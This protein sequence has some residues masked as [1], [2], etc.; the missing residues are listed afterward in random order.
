[1]RQQAQRMQT[2]V[3]DLLT[4]ARIEG[5]AP[6]APDRWVHLEA[7]VDA[8]RV[9]ATALSAGRHRLHW[10]PVREAVLLGRTELA[11]NETELRSALGNLLS[12]AVRYTPEGGEVALLLDLRSDGRLA[13]TVRDSGIGIAAE[14]L[15]RI[16]ERFYRVDGSRSR[17]TGGTGLG[18]AIVKHVAQRHGGELL[19]ESRP[20]EGS[21]FT[22]VMPAMRVR[23]S[24]GAVVAD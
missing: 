24:A 16:T 20:G 8:V 13:M 17:A 10:P 2:L 5:G 21:T 12:N 7:L 4:L 9:E 18:L 14:H 3:D 15:P 6:P 11:G 1:M 19:V 22:L 23:G